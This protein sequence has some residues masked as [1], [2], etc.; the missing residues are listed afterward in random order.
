MKW[1][2]SIILA[3]AFSTTVDAQPI[4]PVASV[5]MLT[6]SRQIAFQLRWTQREA[7][8][9]TMVAVF[10]S[11]DTVPIL[12]R[13]TQSPDTIRFT[14]PTDTTTY[15]F[16]LVNVRRN[17]VSPPA[18]VNFYFDADK[19]YVP[20]GLSVYPKTITIDSTSTTRQVQFCAFIKFADGTTVIRDRD[21]TIPKC[22][23]YYN[24]IPV[25]QRS[26]GGAKQR[27]A[28]KMCLSWTTTG[29]TIE[30]EVCSG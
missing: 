10:L 11:K 18:N 28:N 17:I 4:R 2:Y 27:V 22:I 8:D 30:N 23:D 29:G 9:S 24:T 16:L 15:R 21:L 19:Y 1:L 5:S 6:A 3:F 25:E 7:V 26:T 20:S 12:Y 14:I 13:R